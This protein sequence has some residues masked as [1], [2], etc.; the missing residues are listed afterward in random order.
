MFWGP[1]EPTAD[2]TQAKQQMSD[3]EMSTEAPSETR[4]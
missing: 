4:Q 2:K 3:S 1:A